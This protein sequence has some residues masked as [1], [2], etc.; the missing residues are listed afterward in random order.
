MSF[1]GLDKWARLFRIIRQNGGIFKTT[2][3]LWRF[4]TLKEG[5][6]VGSDSFGNKYYENNYYMIGRNRWVEFHPKFAW[7]YDATHITSEWYGWLHHKTDN[8]PCEDSA[9][10]YLNCCCYVANWLLPFSENL[11]GTDKAYYPYSTT[12]HHICVWDGCSLCNRHTKT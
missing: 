11:T 7:E 4:D 12:N 1:L 10:Y 9:K 8:R 6:F 3:K 2:Y 5:T